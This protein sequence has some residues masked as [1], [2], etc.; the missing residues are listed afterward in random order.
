MALMREGKAQ[1]WL[2]A[3]AMADELTRCG[4]K[5]RRGRRAGAGRYCRRCAVSFTVAARPA[6]GRRK[7]SRECAGPSSSA[8]PGSGRNERRGER[9][10]EKGKPMI[11]YRPLTA[12]ERGSPTHFCNR[13][14]TV[15]KRSE[16]HHCVATER[17]KRAK[18]ASLTSLSDET[19]V[20][21]ETPKQPRETEMRVS[22]S[23]NE[24]TESQASASALPWEAEGISRSTYFRRRAQ[25]A[26]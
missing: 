20:P 5:T 12:E 4:A 22:V 19:L 2:E 18:A 24:T 8:M 11:D 15:Q 7:A 21:D 1:K 9:P 6:P 23:E 13:C 14:E 10:N 3:V 17:W 25:E 26:V 16:I